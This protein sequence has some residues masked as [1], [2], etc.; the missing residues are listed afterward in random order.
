MHTSAAPRPVCVS[1]PRST[2]LI[3]ALTSVTFLV[4]PPP[5]PSSLIAN[6]HKSHAWLSGLFSH[7]AEQESPSHPPALGGEGEGDPHL[8]LW[9]SPYASAALTMWSPGTLGQPRGHMGSL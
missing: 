7:S 2:A 8:P 3:T 1:Q 4:T 9:S 6:G 5:G